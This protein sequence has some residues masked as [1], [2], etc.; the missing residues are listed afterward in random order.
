MEGIQKNSSVAQSTVG[1]PDGT[2]K[3]PTKVCIGIHFISVVLKW[4]PCITVC[5]IDQC[6]D[7]ITAGD[8][9]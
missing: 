8:Y 4:K 2:K 1:L 5:F 9:F 6:T 3:L 7:I